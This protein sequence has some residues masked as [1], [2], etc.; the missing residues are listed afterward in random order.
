MKN[1]TS[2]RILLFII[3]SLCMSQFSAAQKTWRKLSGFNSSNSIYTITMGQNNKLYTATQD[4]WIYYSTNNG[5][6]W[7]AFTDVPTYF[8]IKQV[9]ASTISPRVFCVSSSSGLVYTDDHG[10]NW[11]SKKLTA[12]GGTSGFGA[13]I[14]AFGVGGNQLIVSVLGSITFPIQ[15]KIF[16]SN[17][18]GNNFAQASDIYFFPWDFHFMRDTFIFSNSNTGLYRADNLNSSWNHVSF[19]GK[20]VYGLAIDNDTIYAAVM[21]SLGGKVYKSIDYGNSWNLLSGLNNVEM[22]SSIAY[23]GV[24]RQLYAT[25]NLG[26][27]AYISNS[28]N[29]IH[30]EDR[31]RI[32]YVAADGSVLFGGSRV[33]GIYKANWQNLNFT[34][35]NEGIGLPADFLEVSRDN[36]LYYGSIYTSFLSKLDLNTLDWSS[37]NLHDSL[38]Y[39]SLISMGL[40]TSGDL[41]VGGLHHITKIWN[42]GDSIKIIADSNSAPLAPVYNILFP[43]KMFLGNNGSI[44]MIQ[45]SSQNYVDYSPDMGGS[46]NRIFESGINGNPYLFKI[47]KLLSGNKSHYLFGADL[48]AKNLILGSDNNGANWDTIP[49]PTNNNL[50]QDIFMDHYNQLYTTTTDSLFSWDTLN[51]EWNA[52][53]I[54]L[55]NDPNKVVEIEFDHSNKMHVL[56]RGTLTAFPEEGLY[57]MDS[58]G[59]SFTKVAFPLVNGKMLRLKFLSFNKDNIPLAV[60]NK[61][62]E[63]GSV[64]NEGIYY[65][66]DKKISSI[67]EYPSKTLLLY[68]NPARNYIYLDAEINEQIVG[69]LINMQGQVL[70]VD[71]QKSRIDLSDIPSGYYLLRFNYH[72]KKY[73]GKL[74]LIKNR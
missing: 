73:T 33:N 26:V 23:D 25:T 41:I 74:M 7:N 31:G 13:T 45:H 14:L 48:R 58:T 56:I 38:P 37:Y 49:G 4:R 60:I 11:I 46:W 34:K 6:Q 42:K 44:S 62:D 27:Y 19:S 5:L 54:N 68:P 28:W 18:N 52:I 21:D 69:E 67:K 57:I 51:Q 64:N 39:T 3:L 50:I 15:N 10:A 20:N 40:D 30:P 71:I 1:P 16:Y 70:P 43:A 17:D 35:A 2:S 55:G 24:N 8:D 65:F 9:K 53:N 29:K 12:G 61:S 63:G 72:N 47:E 22:I 36:Q 59:S 66:S 32:I